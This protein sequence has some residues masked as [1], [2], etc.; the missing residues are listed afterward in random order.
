MSANTRVT[1]SQ[2]EIFRACTVLMKIVEIC[3]YFRNKKNVFL[4]NFRSFLKFSKCQAFGSC[5]IFFFEI[6]HLQG[7]LGG[8][9]V[10]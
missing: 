5:L 10:I 4:A 9:E 6:V 7:C 3:T 2:Y 1:S 8:I